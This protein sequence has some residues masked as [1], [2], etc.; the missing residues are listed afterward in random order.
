VAKIAF[1]KE[2][3]NRLKIGGKRKDLALAGD[4]HE[5]NKYTKAKPVTDFLSEI[6]QCA[7]VSK[8]H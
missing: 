8:R 3:L 1:L 5:W 2:Q 6:K 7:K 4:I